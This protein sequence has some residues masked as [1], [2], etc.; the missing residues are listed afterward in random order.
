MKAIKNQAIAA[1][2]KMFAEMKDDNEI[3]SAVLSD[4]FQSTQLVASISLHGASYEV[5]KPK[6]GGKLEVIK[7]SVPPSDKDFKIR[8]S[9]RKIK[10][11]ILTEIVASVV[12]AFCDTEAEANDFVKEL[13]KHDLKGKQDNQGQ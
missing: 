10:N 11:D 1:A 9:T 3:I 4:K 13:G 8:V 12:K 2:N 6:A 5:W 7:S